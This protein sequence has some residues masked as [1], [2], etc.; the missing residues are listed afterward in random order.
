M[1]LYEAWHGTKLVVHHLHTFC[2]VAFVED[3]THNLKK[4]NDRSHPMIF[5]G[6]EQGIKGYRVYDPL[7][8]WVRVLR[9][10]VFDEQAKWQWGEAEHSDDSIG[11]TFTVEYNLSCEQ[12]VVKGA[13][14]QEEEPVP[15]DGVHEAGGD[16]SNQG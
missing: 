7:T 12:V 10:I 4:L 11:D 3:T 8:R 9:D 14:E 15:V 5:N 13:A 16:D 6:Y 1:T 2:C